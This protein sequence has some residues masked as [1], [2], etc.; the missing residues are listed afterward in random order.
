LE[1][2]VEITRSVLWEGVMVKK[3]VKVI[4]SIITSSREVKFDQ[5]GKVV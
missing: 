4:D 1:K 3:G 2:G 5:M